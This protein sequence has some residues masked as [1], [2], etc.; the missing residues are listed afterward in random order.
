MDLNETIIARTDFLVMSEY[1]RDYRDCVRQAVDELVK[2][3]FLVL[4]SDGR[5]R[6]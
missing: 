5:Y 3:G 6:K 1:S 2:D 4:L